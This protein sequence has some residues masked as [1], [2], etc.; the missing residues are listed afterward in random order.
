MTFLGD[1]NFWLAWAVEDH[2]H[3]T[4]ATNWYR[5]TPEADLLFCRI[6]QKGLLRLLTNPHVMKGDVLT[7]PGAWRAYDTL[8]SNRRVGFAGEP[9]GLEQAWRAATQDSLKGPNFWTDAYLTAFA[10]A[11]GFVVLT[12]DR[13]LAKRAGKH[14]RFLAA[15]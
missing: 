9:P 13:E 10:M 7:G 3:H 5:E 4:I 12:F 15:T 1:V 6:T 14:A 8:R 11:A 2:I